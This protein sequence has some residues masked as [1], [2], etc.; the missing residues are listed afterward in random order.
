MHRAS[1]FWARLGSLQDSTL[2]PV[3]GIP[4]PN[5]QRRDEL[6]H[7]FDKQERL[8]GEIRTPEKT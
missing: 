4:W 8:T 1:I 7:T 3:T 6:T 2:H 5:A